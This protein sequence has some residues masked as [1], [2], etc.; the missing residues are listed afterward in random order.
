MLEIRISF[1]DN[2]NKM[3]TL[4][5]TLINPSIKHKTIIE[6]FDNLKNGEGFILHNDHDPKPLFYQLSATKGDTFTWEYLQQGPDIF[7]IIIAKKSVLNGEDETKE[8]ILDGISLHPSEKFKTI[9]ATYNHLKEGESFILHNDHDPKPLFYQ[10]SATKGETFTWEYLQQGPEIFDIRIGKTKS[11]D[12]ITQT[13]TAESKIEANFNDQI[14]F[15]ESIPET[16]RT[17]VAKDYRTSSVFQKFGINYAWNGNRTIA[18]ICD[19]YLIAEEK[20]RRELHAAISDYSIFLPSQDYYHWGMAFLADYILN[21]HHRYVKENAERISSFAEKMAFDFPT[22]EV[23]VEIG[24]KTRPMIDDF[25]VHMSKEEDVLFPA[26]KQMLKVM[27]QGG[28]SKG[29]GGAIKNAVHKMES[30]HD[31]TLQY[32]QR[33]RQITNNYDETKLTSEEQKRMYHELQ[34]FENDANKH[35]HLENNI[36]FPKLI[37]LEGKI[38]D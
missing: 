36:L 30:E 24:A 15:D 27:Q 3:K 11:K 2:P 21:T 5:A 32:L 1:N 13:A 12:K 26:I 16:V 8:F 17:I 19:E 33:F 14:L 35:V 28:K 7:E 20:L 9:M 23:F 25:L 37:I 34:S 18:E 22:N 4:D 6:T 38:T 31:E 29:P 10:L